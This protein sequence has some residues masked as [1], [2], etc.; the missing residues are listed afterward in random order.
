MG[1]ILEDE[2]TQSSDHLAPAYVGLGQRR[3]GPAK[4]PAYFMIQ[5]P[6]E[7]SHPGYIVLLGR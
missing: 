1:T 7:T 4:T 3:Q 2:W 6:S 5:A